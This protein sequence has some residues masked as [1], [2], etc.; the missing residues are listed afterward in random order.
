M[1]VP[2]TLFPAVL[3][4]ARIAI[5]ASSNQA[6][7][8]ATL[9]YADRDGERVGAVLTELGSIA[10]EDVW[11]LPNTTVPALR[12]ALDRAEERALREP[13][14]TIIVYYSGHADA[15][16]L[17]IGD[18]RFSYRE[19]RERLARSRAQVRVAVLDA[20]NAGGA[21]RPKGGHQGGGPVF[22]PVEP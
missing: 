16:G 4:A 3:L 21:T 10:S 6:D 1:I 15:E 13:A 19:L 17:L 20:C 22:T 5:V 11:K 12:A 2:V 7:G 9:R 14:S 8:Q 18:Q